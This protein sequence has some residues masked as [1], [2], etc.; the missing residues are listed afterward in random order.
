ML[1]ERRRPY[2]A[3]YVARADRALSRLLS[4]H[5]FSPFAV[6]LMEFVSGGKRVRPVLLYLSHEAC[7]GGAEPDPDPAA[8]AVELIHTASLIH[9]DLI[10]GDR[11]RR[12]KLAFHVRFGG[13]LAI[14]ISDFVLSLV[15]DVSADYGDPRIARAL[16][17]TTRVMSEGEAEEARIRARREPI[18]FETYLRI[19][20]KKT[21]SLF[22]ASAELGA[23]I[24]GAEDRVISGMAEFGRLVGMAYQLRDDLLDFGKPGEISSLVEAKPVGPIGAASEDFAQRAVD[25]LESLVSPSEARDLLRELA[26]YATRWE[27]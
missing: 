13:D 15:L 24:A 19:L 27:G 14:L 7:G 9:D 11:V 26:L 10:D 25:L 18:S 21:A 4:E 2:V 6:P 5:A 22:S 1:R 8:A 17:R 20:E 3:P 23:I 12:G 16:A